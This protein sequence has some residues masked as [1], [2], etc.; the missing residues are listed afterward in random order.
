VSYAGY[1]A[2][3]VLP[4]RGLTPLSGGNPNYDVYLTQDQKYVALGTLEPKFWGKFC[5][6][7]QK[8]DWKMY[9]VPQNPTQLA[10]YKA[11]I[12]TL[13]CS[14]TQ[15]EWIQ[16]GQANDL[17][18]SAVHSLADLANDPHLQH[19]QMIVEQTHPTAGLLRSIGV[20]IKFLGT[21][22]EPA[23]PTPTL[24]QDTAEVLGPMGE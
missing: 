4:E 24:G 22:A 19:R 9:M 6:L 20:P 5:D 17:L 10:Q 14:K 12:A 15:A 7:L 1:A 3:G 11:E 18:I 21:P 23:W 8:P 16:W 2:S 13:F